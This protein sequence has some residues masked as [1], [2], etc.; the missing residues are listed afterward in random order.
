MY[1][2]MTHP[3][4]NITVFQALTCLAEKYRFDVNN[5]DKYRQIIALYLQG[6]QNQADGDVLG[7]LLQD[8]VLLDYT[9]IASMPKDPIRREFERKL[10]HLTLLESLDVLDLGLLERHVTSILEPN[11]PLPEYS[12][13]D[14]GRTTPEGD[15]EEVRDEKLNLLRK[16]ITSSHQLFS[17]LMTDGTSLFDLFHQPTSVP[18]SAIPGTFLIQLGTIAELLRANQCIYN[19]DE[20]H[21]IFNQVQLKYYLCSLIAYDVS[22]RDKYN[23]DA[24]FC[25]LDMQEVQNVF[26]PLLPGFLSSLNL[27]AMFSVHNQQAFDQALTHAIDK[28]RELFQ[29]RQLAHKQRLKV[30]YARSMTLDLPHKKV[31]YTLFSPLGMENQAPVKIAH[32]FRY[33]QGNRTQD[34]HV[35]DRTQE[36]YLVMIML[37][38][39]RVLGVKLMKKKHTETKDIP[40]A[41][42]FALSMLIGLLTEG[43]L[44]V[45]CELPSSNRLNG[46]P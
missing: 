44:D 29:N 31:G 22:C 19:P 11:Q 20:L 28:N 5:I 46:A 25:V 36:F 9:I 17:E 16:A 4:L 35:I 33:F 3:R 14:S 43:L 30:T 2:T 38:I 12:S 1:S 37:L 41:S 15:T 18:I 21:P 26:Q 34:A 45:N 39:A 32:L 6:I 40:F 42:M 13:D 7:I 27:E 24:F 10:A 8:P 23:L